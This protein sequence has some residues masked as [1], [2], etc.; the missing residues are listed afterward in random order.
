MNPSNGKVLITGTG[1]SGT[2]FLMLLL[3]ELGFDT[4][5]DY[6]T[7]K[8]SVLSANCKA[9]LEECFKAPFY[10]LKN[11]IF[12]VQID[13]I[14]NTG[15]KID[16]VFIPVRNMKDAAQSRIK[17]GKKKSGGL[18]GTKDKSKQLDVLYQF[19]GK[20]VSDL[21]LLDIPHT[22]MLF[23]K[24]IEDWRYCYDKLSFLLAGKIGIAE[25]R[26]AFNK[27]AMPELINDF[28]GKD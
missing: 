19:L 24:I 5:R 14:V 7:S 16:H 17:F 27:T 9:G 18:I 2:T 22:F 15:I 8:K 20:L 1:R 10:I 4:G 13:E 11:P 28:S 23:P 12:S 26:K 21:V 6:E 3:T 25:F